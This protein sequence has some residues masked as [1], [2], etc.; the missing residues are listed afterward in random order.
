M[1]A[2]SDSKL[3]ETS[4][5]QSATFPKNIPCSGIPQYHLER[6]LTRLD[7]HSS[8]L[9]REDGDGSVDVWEYDDFVKGA[10]ICKNIERV[11][12]VMIM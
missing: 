3:L 9:F 5:L 2:P 6:Y 11:S 8:R 10:T 1:S 4:C 7:E 12:H